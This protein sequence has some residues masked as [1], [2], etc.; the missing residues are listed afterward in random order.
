VIQSAGGFGL[1]L[2]EIFTLRAHAFNE[3]K[4]NL[5]NTTCQID[6]IFW[7]MPQAVTPF[8]PT[9][10][11]GVIESRQPTDDTRSSQAQAPVRS[12]PVG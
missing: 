3:V 11:T 9:N 5:A 4:S 1:R 2:G 7:G 12:R 6:G 10:H 8:S